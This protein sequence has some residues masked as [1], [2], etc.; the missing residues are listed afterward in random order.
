MTALS[1]VI[2]S[3]SLNPIADLGD[4]LSYDFMRYAFLAGTAM[5]LLGGLVGYFVVLRHLAFAGEALSHVA[6]AAALGAVL[7]G[8]DPLLGMFVITVA[9]ALGMGTL[10]D[11]ARTHDV[12]V[13]TVLAWVLG[14]GA[15]FLSIYTSSP[16]AGSNGQIGV[17]VLFGS[18]LGVQLQQAQE[19]ALIGGAATVLLLAMARPLLFA[20]LDPSVAL[21]RGVRVRLLGIVFLGLVAVTVA[22]A[23]QVVGA[24]LVLALLV[25]PAAIAQRLTAR[26]FRALFISAGLA[27]AFTW[28]GLAV[29]FYTPYPVSFWITTLAF[30]VYVFTLA[31]SR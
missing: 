30:G 6:F 26:P 20:T 31:W 4:M 2:A 17:N 15:L 5:A 8:A 25:M 12:A 10:A 22:E 27:V 19:A 16:S 7:L 13:G 18:I 9:V 29:G 28:V 21:V 23:V 3:L 11:Q 14:L 24:L 1:P